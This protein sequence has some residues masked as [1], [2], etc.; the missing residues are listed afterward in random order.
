[1]LLEAVRGLPR[2]EFVIRINEVTIRT[3]KT[4]LHN[5]GRQGGREAGRQGKK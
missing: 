4:I 2:R 5:A 1:M 3:G